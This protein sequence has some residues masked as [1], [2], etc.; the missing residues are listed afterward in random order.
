M[1]V[2]LLVMSHTIAVVAAYVISFLLND[3][4]RAFGII[5][6]FLTSLLNK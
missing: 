6:Y 1:I 4:V 3:P 5:F 2:T